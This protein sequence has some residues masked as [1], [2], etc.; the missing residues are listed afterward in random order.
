MK[1]TGNSIQVCFVAILE[2]EFNLFNILASRECHVLESLCHC[3]K[4]EEI[5]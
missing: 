1:R 5:K 2:Y 3:V 4:F